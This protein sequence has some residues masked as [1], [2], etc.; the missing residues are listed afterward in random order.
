MSWWHPQ[1]PIRERKSINLLIKFYLNS[2]SCKPCT[3]NNW[4]FFFLMHKMA[5][6]N[7]PESHES[8]TSQYHTI[9]SDWV[10]C[11]MVFIIPSDGSQGLSLLLTEDFAC[12]PVGREMV[13]RLLQQ[14]FPG[15]VETQTAHPPA[16]PSPQVNEASRFFHFFHINYKPISTV[17][18]ILL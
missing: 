1:S 12:V 9:T 2:S 8:Q 5:A 17:R 18:V 11:L 6:S 16:A 3:C 10:C 7:H 14:V 13:W 15:W 4:F